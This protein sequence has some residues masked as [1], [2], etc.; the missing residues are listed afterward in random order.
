MLI[1]R[2]RFSFDMPL[3]LIALALTAIGIVMIFSSSG[4]IAGDKYGQPFHFMIQQLIGAGAGLA[5]IIVLVSIKK[6]FFLE[7]VFI[8]GLLGLTVFMLM[9][10]FLMPTVAKTNRWLILPGFR[11]QPSELAKIS[12]I[13]FLAAYCEKKKERINEW[14]V[15]AV[16]AAVLGIIVILIL[17]EPDFGTAVLVFALGAMMLF[18]ARLKLRYFLAIGLVA[19]LVFAFT[20]FRSDYRV[21]RVQS[22]LSVEKD[23]LDRGYQVNQSKLALGSGG[24]IGVGLGQSTQ[25]LY[26]LPYAHTDF[27]YSILGEELGLI[28]TTG[29]LLLFMLLLWRGLKIGFAAPGPKY[30]MIAAGLT[31][32]I[33]IQ[34][35]LNMTVV[36]GLGPAKGIPLP[37]VSYGRSSL[38]CTLA[39]VGIILHISQRKTGTV[40]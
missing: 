12:L 33:V 25:K 30:K 34:A 1:G 5:A 9:L 18:M 15:L 24:V 16:P 35:L 27:I 22:F 19:V 23:V 13:L 8:Y 17:M 4:Y 10:C 7:P 39:A 3:M 36:L 21:E 20:L 28:G 32:A 26:F 11:F 6:S 38:L 2:R 37:F 31:L 29:G 14:K 40:R